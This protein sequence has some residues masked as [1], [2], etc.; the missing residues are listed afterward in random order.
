MSRK[1][2]SIA[3]ANQGP[4]SAIRQNFLSAAVGNNQI[5]D[6]VVQGWQPNYVVLCV[7]TLNFATS[8]SKLNVSF[9]YNLDKSAIYKWST[10][11]TAGFATIEAFATAARSGVAFPSTDFKF[12]VDAG[13]P[14]QF[15]VPG[16][17]YVVMV[18]DNLN[19]QFQSTGP[20]VTLGPSGPIHYT[21]LRQLPPTVSPVSGSAFTGDGCQVLYFN[22]YVPS[23]PPYS[24]PPI[25]GMIDPFNLLIEFTRSDANGNI[26]NRVPV[27]VDPDI[28]NDG[29][30]PPAPPL[31]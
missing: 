18:L 20:G 1:M 14:M 6:G 23:E 3:A 27:C 9:G 12:E 22:A 21:N 7:P 30:T 11:L 29:T 31:I 8:N 15:R 28:K 24:Q 19:W 17:G 25:P 13:N 2:H 5:Q 16:S 26:T 10:V 4:L